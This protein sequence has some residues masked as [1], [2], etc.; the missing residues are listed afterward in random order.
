MDESNIIMLNVTSS[1]QLFAC[2]KSRFCKTTKASTKAFRKLSLEISSI[3]FI[4]KRLG[5][6]F[7]KVELIL[8]FKRQLFV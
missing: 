4:G 7:E 3:G 6:V 1:N 5:L 8:N 2:L